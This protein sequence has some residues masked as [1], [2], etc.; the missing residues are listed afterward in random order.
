[1]GRGHLGICRQEV[2]S[3]LSNSTR[4]ASTAEAAGTLQRGVAPSAQDRAAQHC[5]AQCVVQRKRC[6]STPTLLPHPH[7]PMPLGT[8]HSLSFLLLHLPGPSRGPA[9]GWGIQAMPS[10]CRKCVGVKLPSAPTQAPPRSPTNPVASILRAAHHPGTRW[11][12][13]SPWQSGP[14]LAALGLFQPDRAGEPPGLQ[15]PPPP[16]PLGPGVS[17]RSR[18]RSPG[19]SPSLQETPPP[20][21]FLGR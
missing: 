4:A 7:T 1:M 13:L 9:G 2:P 20:L 11:A 19:L 16:P 12:S 21:S 5:T 6:L 3:Q 18:C 15:A 17:L 10:I 8:P 14:G